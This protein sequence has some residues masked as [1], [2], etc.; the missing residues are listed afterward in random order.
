ME[1]A[2]GAEIAGGKTEVPDLGHGRDFEEIPQSPARVFIV[3]WRLH[4]GLA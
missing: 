4:M 2:G 3:A 1:A